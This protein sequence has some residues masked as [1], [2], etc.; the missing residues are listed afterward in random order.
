MPWVPWVTTVAEEEAAGEVKAVY[1]HTRSAR[2]GRVP[3][4]V[5]LTSLT[6]EVARAIFELNRAIHRSA[7]GLS[8]REQ[9][10]VALVVSAFNGCVH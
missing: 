3:D 9:E 1:D 8:V 4:F 6:P 10:V 7:R 5:R 2:S